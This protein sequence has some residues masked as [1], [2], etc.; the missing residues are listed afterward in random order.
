MSKCDVL[1]WNCLDDVCTEK[2]IVLMKSNILSQ[3]LLGKHWF[4][5]SQLFFSFINDC[6]MH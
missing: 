3:N 1:V 5:Q 2:S 6:K 4:T